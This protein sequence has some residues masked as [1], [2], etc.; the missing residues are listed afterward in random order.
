M[1]GFRENFEEGYYFISKTNR[2]AGQF[3]LLVT[4]LRY[5]VVLWANPRYNIST[6]I[7]ISY[8]LPQLVVLTLVSSLDE[9]SLEGKTVLAEQENIPGCGWPN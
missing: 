4:A 8:T 3:W 2:S 6:Y 1:V 9:E 5:Q 7:S